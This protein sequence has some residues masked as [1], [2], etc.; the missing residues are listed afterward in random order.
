MNRNFD[1]E[2]LNPTTR[3]N[4][5]SSSTY[6]THVE[7]L[8]DD[9]ELKGN[10]IQYMTAGAM[11]GLVEHAVMYPIDTIK[12]YVQSSN[13]GILQSIRAIGSLKN[14]YSG[15]TVVLYGALPSH[16]FYFATYEAVKRLFQGGREQHFTSNASVSAIAGIA[17]TIGHDGIATPID[18]IK[19]HMQ[20][21]GHIQNYNFIN[22][23][24][25][26]YALRGLRGFFVSLPT[27]VLMNIPY[28]SVHFVTYEFMKKKLFEHDDHHDHDHHDH[29]HDHD[30]DKWKHVK[31][32]TAGGLAGAAGGL[33]SNPFD[34]VKTLLQVGQASNV[35]EALSLLGSEPG[36]LV[37]N[38]FRGS[39]P[40]VVFFTP[41]AAVTWTTYEYV[42]Y[43][44]RLLNNENQ[45]K[46]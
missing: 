28:T 34:V 45:E 21:K 40:R 5:S 6:Y 30:E 46:K 42:K 24:R 22:A 20:L 29:H 44:F 36:G 27:T 2:E 10:P 35:R 18:V 39:I 17:A 37:R 1:E 43:M 9:E 3:L 8:E 32:F 41:S 14:Y 7:E 4:R 16:A 31:H 26:I 15:L 25:E 13:K 11:A 23:S 12:T 33:V 19:Q 38:L